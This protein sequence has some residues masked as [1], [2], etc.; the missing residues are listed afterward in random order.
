MPNKQ[1]QSGVRFE[2]EV[3]KNRQM[4]GFQT[5]RASGSHGVYDIVCF[6]YGRKPE[7]VQC[8]VTSK[9]SVAKKILKDFVENTESSFYFHQTMSVKVKGNKNP[10]EVTI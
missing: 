9:E 5:I 2:R 3:I 7:F 4:K 8:K 10:V 6:M 1:Y